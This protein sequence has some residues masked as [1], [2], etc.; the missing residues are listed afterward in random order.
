MKAEYLGWIAALGL[1]LIVLIPSPQKE[2]KRKPIP[3]PDIEDVQVDEEVV[4]LSKNAKLGKKTAEA[5]IKGYVEAFKDLKAEDI[6]D[7]EEFTKKL[8]ELTS[9][10]LVDACDPFDQAMQKI[11]QADNFDEKKGAKF[12]NDMITGF[13]SVLSKP[14]PLKMAACSCEDGKSCKCAEGECTC[15]D[16]KCESCKGK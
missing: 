10:M 14:T 8:S 12:C 3:K 15:P 2:D 9:A 4:E 1:G 7:G 16:C 11:V 5:I 6:D 13:G